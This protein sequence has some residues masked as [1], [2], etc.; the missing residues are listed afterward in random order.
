MKSPLRK[1][2]RIA[3]VLLSFALLFNFFGYYFIYIKSQ[4]NEKLVHIISIA[5]QQRMLSQSI[6][7]NVVLLCNSQ[8][9]QVSKKKIK[10]NLQNALTDFENSDKF[11]RCEL[12][13]EGI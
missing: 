1:L 8:Q 2:V 6:S 11:F 5:G 4:E 10:D 9:N 13:I 12:T 7:K 3:I